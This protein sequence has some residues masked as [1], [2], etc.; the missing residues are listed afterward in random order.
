MNALR[1][2]GP[3]T[4]GSRALRQ[5]SSSWRRPFSQCTD[6]NVRMKSA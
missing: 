1:E 3:L 5:N 2:E 6:I 4:L